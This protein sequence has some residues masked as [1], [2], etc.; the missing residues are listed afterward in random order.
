VD[1]IDVGTKLEF[2]PDK[3]KEKKVANRIDTD[4]I[5]YV[6][7]NL[8]YVEGDINGMWLQSKKTRKGFRFNLGE[9]NS[10]F[11]LKR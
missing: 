10:L 2:K 8:E 4:G 9:I 7:T 1:K 3:R 11:R 6:V 5:E